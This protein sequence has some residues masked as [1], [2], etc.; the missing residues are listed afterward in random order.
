MTIIQGVR[1]RRGG[2]SRGRPTVE[3]EIYVV[4]GIGRAIAPAGASTGSGEAVD[5]RDGDPNFGG[6]DVRNALAAVDGEIADALVGMDASDQAGVDEVL[7]ALD[8]TPNKSRLGGNAIV[9]TSMAVAHA[10][11]AAREVP[12]WRYLS[13]S[14]TGMMPLPEI[15]IFGGGAH[16]GR[17]VDV[18][19]FMVMA[20]GA[21]DYGEALDWTARVYLAAGKL[22][23]ERGDLQG[24]ADEGGY[25]PAFETNEAALDML[26]R[27]IEA[28]GLVPG[29]QVTISLDIAASEF[30]SKGRYWLGLEGRELDSD[31]LSEMLLG[32]LN[33]YPIVSVEDPLGEDDEAGLIAFTAA[34]GD[35]VQIIGY[36]FLVTDAARVRSAVEKGA[37][38]AVL[39]KPNQAGTLTEAK[40][41]FETAK[42]AGWGAVI[43]ARSGETEDLTIVHLAVGWQ[44]RQLKV[45]SFARSERMAKW[46]EGLRVAEVVG[47]ALPTPSMFPW[48][49]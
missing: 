34:V 6:Y 30:G 36:D 43:S 3:T 48:G 49:V 47:P 44:A 42:C 22:M 41:A 10:A 14:A 16:A 12:L 20:T 13:G 37:C 28:A 40:A 31:G 35:A 38:N 25:W 23:A 8:G 11:A 24:V 18:Q 32:W 33:R 46:N 1:G 29:E 39:V 27:S 5:L 15:Q 4:G 21:T 2:D 19:D 17:R 45:G 26:V 9:A 7:I